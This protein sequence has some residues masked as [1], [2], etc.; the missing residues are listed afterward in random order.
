MLSS[1]D[2]SKH[3]AITETWCV[4]HDITCR[5]MNFWQKKK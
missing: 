3:L 1:R 2:I 5:T 4:Y